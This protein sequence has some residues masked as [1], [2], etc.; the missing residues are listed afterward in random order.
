MTQNF[1]MPRRNYCTQCDDYGHDA[2]AHKE[3]I[4]TSEFRRLRTIKGESDWW[5]NHE[6]SSDEG[7][8]CLFCDKIIDW[9]PSDHEVACPVRR[10]FGFEEE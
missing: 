1:G 8:V 3:Y 7:L 10:F 4:S 9:A 6:L 2:Q 5:V